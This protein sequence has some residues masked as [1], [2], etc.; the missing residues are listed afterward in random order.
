MAPQRTGFLLSPTV[1]KSGEGRFL[2]RFWCLFDWGGLLAEVAL[3]QASQGLA[4]AGLV[5]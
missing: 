5:W 3:Q 4:V 1:R 2:L